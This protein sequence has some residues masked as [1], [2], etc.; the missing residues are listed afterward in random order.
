ALAAGCWDYRDLERRSP[1]LGMA[2]D[3]RPDS[4]GRGY[5]VTV[6]IPDPALDSPPGGGGGGGGRAGGGGDGSQ[7]SKVIVSGEGGTLGAEEQFAEF[8]RF[9]R[10][11]DMRSFDHQHQETG[12]A[13][14][15]R[16]ALVAGRLVAEG[17][18]I[19]R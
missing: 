16:V 12:V 5:K 15:P 19:V 6:E 17:A 14:L 13:L 3:G 10:V 2:V 4:G 11:Q 7:S 1:I 18:A 8:P 9:A